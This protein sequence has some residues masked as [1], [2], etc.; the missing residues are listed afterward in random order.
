MC[1]RFGRIF[2]IL[3]QLLGKSEKEAL[4]R[5]FS[6]KP[7]PLAKEQ[8]DNE[9]VGTA[10]TCIQ[11]LGEYV[12]LGVSEFLLIFPEPYTLDLLQ[13]FSRSYPRIVRVRY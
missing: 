4:E 10:D 9:I 3:E 12:D 6:V 7:K 5:A 13:E 11:K 2:P 1:L 8:V